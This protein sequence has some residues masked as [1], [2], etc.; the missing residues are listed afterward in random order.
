[1]AGPWTSSE[2]ETARQARVTAVL[3]F[4]GAFYKFDRSYAPHDR[5]KGS[6]RIQVSY[7]GRD[8]R[9]I[10]TGEKWINELLSHDQLHRG[11]GG[12]IDFV[13]HVTGL[14]FVPAVK[15]CLDSIVA[16]SSEGDKQQ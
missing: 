16:C 6:F 4:L 7:Q 5:S 10:V 15:I 14:G 1:M 12:S 8:F 11:G 3:D 2:I 13:R 9:F